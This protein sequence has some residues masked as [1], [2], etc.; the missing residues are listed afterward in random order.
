[1]RSGGLAVAVG[2]LVLGL[3]ADVAGTTDGQKDPVLDKGILP[4]LGK[5]FNRAAIQGTIR[6]H[7][8]DPENTIPRIFYCLNGHMMSKNPS[9]PNN[10]NDQER[11]GKERPNMRLA[12]DGEPGVQVAHII[13]RRVVVQRSTREYQEKL[14]AARK[15]LNVVI[16][17]RENSYEALSEREGWR[18]E[19]AFNPA[20]NYSFEEKM[21]YAREN[22][23]GK[24][25]NLAF[26]SRRR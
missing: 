6:V 21:R 24:S 15:E 11:A 14:G 22:A 19:V 17:E 8:R 3:G 23:D 7:M 13:E 18:R 25:P 4:V 20:S 2:L 10:M 16:D 26:P 12:M 9:A 1:M 5:L